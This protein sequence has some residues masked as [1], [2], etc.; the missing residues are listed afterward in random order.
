M[1]EQTICYAAFMKYQIDDFI[2]DAKARTLSDI[3]QQQNVRPKTLAVLLYLA[4][5]SGNIISKQ[6]LL[7]VI[8]D[9]VNVDDGVIFQSIREIRQ[10]FSNA[11]IIQN[12]PRKGYEFTTSLEPVAEHSDKIDQ[13]ASQLVTNSESKKTSK[14]ATMLKQRKYFPVLIILLLTIVSAFVYIENISEPNQLNSKHSNKDIHPKYR[15]NIVVMPIK[16]KVP[17]GEHEWVYLGAMEQLIAKL[18]ALPDAIYVHQGSYIPRLMH[19]AGISRDFSSAEVNKIFVVS[20]AS[21]IIEAE[22]Y[23]NVADYKLIYKFH[24]A[25]DVKQG[26]ILGKSVNDTLSTL[27]EKIAAFIQQPLQRNADL[28]M[29]EFNDALFAKAIINYEADWQTS[30]SFFESYLALNP[31]STIAAI[32]LSKLYLWNDRVEQAEKLILTTEK[33]IEKSVL[34]TAEIHLIKAKI[35]VSKQHWKIAE[36]Q[37]LLATNTLK[38]QNEWFLQANIAEARGLSYLKQ[39]L[40]TESAQA[41]NAALTFYQIIDSPIGINATQLHLANVLFQQGKNQQASKLYR[42]TK[43]DIEKTKLEFLYG[44]LSEYSAKFQRYNINEKSND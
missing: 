39:K 4:Q 19:M 26:A 6:E 11:K 23:G 42:Q 37:F 29:K 40:L 38:S 34:E 32:Y 30:I 27:A 1:P 7:A 13:T 2:L 16:N 8:W 43:N 12:H 3:N 22:L 9:D 25:N 21:L 5:R 44:M 33:F 35:A 36:R 17:Y 20:G 28:P 41:F 14:I 18:T 31:T 24:L 15:Q 10:L